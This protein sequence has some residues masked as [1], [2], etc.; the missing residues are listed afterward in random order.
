MRRLAV[1]LSAFLS[2]AGLLE[3]AGRCVAVFSGI[4]SFFL[5]AIFC[6]EYWM[7]AGNL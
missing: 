3:P 4:G 6:V 5:V 1:C 7:M 2:A